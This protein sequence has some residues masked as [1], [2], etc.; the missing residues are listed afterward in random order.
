M[1]RNHFFIRYND[2]EVIFMTLDN[3]IKK[4]FEVLCSERSISL[5]Q[6]CRDAGVSVSDLE[7]P[8]GI[9]FCTVE[10]LCTALQISLSDFFCNELFSRS[11]H[12]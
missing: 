11:F 2:I 6:L 5:E 1:G 9:L 4:R 10:Y 8:G 12:E 7:R 3:A